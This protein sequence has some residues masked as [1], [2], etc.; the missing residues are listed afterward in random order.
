MEFPKGEVEAFEAQKNRTAFEEAAQEDARRRQGAQ[1]QFVA[2]NAKK[3]ST[4]NFPE[5]SPQE[6]PAPQERPVMDRLMER[7]AAN[8]F[9][10]SD[11]RPTTDRQSAFG[12]RPILRSGTVQLPPKPPLIQPRVGEEDYSIVLPEQIRDQEQSRRS[13]Q[14]QT[15]RDTAAAMR[16]ERERVEA[17]RQQEA[18]RLAADERS[19]NESA[20]DSLAND[21]E[22]MLLGRAAINQEHQNAE[23]QSQQRAFDAVERAKAEAHSDRLRS[24]RD[25]RV[26]KVDALHLKMAY[27]QDPITGGTEH[28]AAIDKAVANGESIGGI[29]RKLY[30]DR[31]VA[32]MAAYRNKNR[33]LNET[34]NMMDPR[35]A[36][37][38]FAR[39]I[40]QAGND[41]LKQAAVYRQFG[42]HR[43]AEALENQ[44]IAREGI[45]SGERV[46]NA[47]AADLRDDKRFDRSIREREAAVNERNAGTAADVARNTRDIGIGANSNEAARIAA[48]R[49]KNENML[50]LREDELTKEQR[51]ERDRNETEQLKA[52]V[53]PPGQMIKKFS[54]QA[55]S[56]ILKGGNFDSVMSRHQLNLASVPGLQTVDPD[57]TIM[58][59]AREGLGQSP[60]GQLR[61]Y[62]SHFGK[63]IDAAAIAIAHKNHGM[64]SRMT[65]GP[66]VEKI[67]K[68]I[69]S[70]LGITDESVLNQATEVAI[71]SLS[72]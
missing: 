66:D 60:D 3:A 42:M 51:I 12:P 8:G 68:K 43:Q 22:Q 11:E 2:D 25:A 63:V 26:A 21:R 53:V 33:M 19:K 6:P 18:L 14:Q 64:W 71:N 57:S 47:K 24:G 72:R 13:S 65:G 17:A 59:L 69:A 9:P 61:R 32:G 4:L 39:S 45:A 41:P 35:M 38:M 70:T 34:R 30:E 46:E 49:E 50:R 15:I 10:I 31:N 37:A 40:E 52:G 23:E 56:E 20:I 7:S 54:S 55:I 48:E 1:R 67:R 58:S 28:L 16:A 5:S 44:A 27:P 36:P 62:K 29:R